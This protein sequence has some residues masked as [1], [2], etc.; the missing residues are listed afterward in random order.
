MLDTTSL[1][2]SELVAHGHINPEAQRELRL[3]IARILA[4][5]PAGT[6]IAQKQL[7]LIAALEEVGKEYPPDCQI[8]NTLAVVSSYLLGVGL[9][10]AVSSQPIADRDAMI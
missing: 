10:T 2:V 3:A 5:A 9:L 7:V 1:A 4:N 6:T 8:R